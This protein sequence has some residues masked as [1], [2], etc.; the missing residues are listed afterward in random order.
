MSCANAERGQKSGGPD[1]AW[2][3]SQE[4]KFHATPEPMGRARPSRRARIFVVQRHATI[5]LHYDFRL[6]F[7]GVLVSWAVPKGPSMNPAD[8]R[9]AIRT[10]DHPIEYAAFE[11]SL[12]ANTAPGR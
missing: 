2:G 1:A 9:V 10:E 7:H 11:G 5:R 8:K 12:T 6:A 3:L 4:E